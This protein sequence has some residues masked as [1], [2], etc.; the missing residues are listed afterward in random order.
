MAAV[1]LGHENAK[2][3]LESWPL[4]KAAAERRIARGKPV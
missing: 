2:E 4:L 3:T 1:N